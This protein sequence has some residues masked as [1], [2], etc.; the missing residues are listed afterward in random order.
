MAAASFLQEA[1]SSRRQVGRE[2]GAP[3]VD[4]GGGSCGVVLEEGTGAG[5]R[6]LLMSQRLKAGTCQSRDG[7]A[8]SWA[9]PLHP[10]PPGEAG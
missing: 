5:P 4:D 7:E 10:A 1:G 3:G 9:F 2:V 8:A 6:S